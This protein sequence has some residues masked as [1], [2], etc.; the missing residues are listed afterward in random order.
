MYIYQCRQHRNSTTANAFTNIENSILKP[1]AHSQN[2]QKHEECH[3]IY[4][5]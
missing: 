3:P 4:E 2:L 1:I 5:N